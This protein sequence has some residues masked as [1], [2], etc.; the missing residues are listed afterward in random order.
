MV[1]LPSVINFFLGF[2][3]LRGTVLILRKACG[4]LAVCAVIL[5]FGSLII[6]VSGLNRDLI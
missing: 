1:F 5:G 4:I 3:K 6:F 2:V